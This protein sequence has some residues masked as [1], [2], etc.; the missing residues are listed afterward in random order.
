VVSDGL[1]FAST[2]ELPLP[3]SL[4][5][6]VIGQE[7]AVRVIRLAARQRRAV[8]LV[9]EPGTGKS[10]L[11]AAMAEL[12]PA[13][14]LEDVIVA[15]NPDGR[16]LPRIRRVPAGEGRARVAEAEARVRR[17]RQGVNYL[18]GVAVVAVLLLGALLAIVATP[19][20][21]AGA[22]LAAGLLLFLRHG[23]L[24][25]RVRSG[26]RVLIDRTGQTRAPFVDATG[27]HAGGLLG[28]V[29]HDPFQS[30]G[31]ETEPH[32]L[33]EPGAIHRA[34]GG[35]LF[36][37]E[38]TALSLESQQR[39]LTALQQ[40]EMAITGR[41][42]GS[43]GA[44]VMTDP[45]P[46]DTVLVVAANPNE[47]AYLHP[48]LRSRLRGFGFELLTADSTER[49]PATE[50][51]LA[52]FV[53]QEVRRDARIP[54]FSPGGVRAVIAEAAR[55][56]G[57]GR[58]TLRLRELGGLVRAAG[59]LAAVEGAAL[60]EA[61]HVDRAQRLALSVEEQL[62]RTGGSPRPGPGLRAVDTTAP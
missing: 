53:A 34:H 36:V 38:I 56:G 5:E 28:D 46:C 48:A 35:V 58:L 52:R 31:Y 2:A 39:L 16:L 62:E 1:R 19:Y 15:A 18:A 12:M 13:A 8:L 9:G 17:E 14:G 6:Q 49:T 3:E 45:V 11:A 37:D 44:M 21:L 60:V 23:A 20:A 10:M 55:R 41:H 32:E 59:D 26:E 30:G 29:R 25:A 40:G 42:S 7:H 22:V 57:P 43:S 24:S 47:L 50:A 54:H 51:A 4:I 27:A 61:V 33:V